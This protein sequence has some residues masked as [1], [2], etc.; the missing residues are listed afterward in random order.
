MMKHFKDQ[1]IDVLIIILTIFLILIISKLWYN[2]FY[3]EFLY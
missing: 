3:L 2:V 1:L